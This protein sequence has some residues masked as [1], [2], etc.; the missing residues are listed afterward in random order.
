MFGFSGFLAESALA[1][2]AVLLGLH[3][4]E[5]FFER[6]RNFAERLGDA[7]H[8]FWV[9]VFFISKHGPS[10]HRDLATEGDSGFFL[11]CLLLATDAVID[12]FGP[13]VVTK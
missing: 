3:G 8:L 9:P 6:L 12:T 2:I 13:G 5:R 4:F 10:Q 7:K 1:L 11:A